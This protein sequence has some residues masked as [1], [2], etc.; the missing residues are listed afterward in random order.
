ME[1]LE[2]LDDL[3]TTRIDTTWP[4]ISGA[5]GLS[6]AVEAL[7]E[8]AEKA[9]DEGVETIILSDRKINH[10]RVGIPS[11]LAV[12]AVHRHLG[13]AKKRMR[14][15]IIIDTAEA[16]D[17]HQMACL[18][19]FGATAICPWLAHE[20]VRELVEKNAKKKFDEVSLDKALINYHKAL[21]KGRS[22]DSFEDGN[23]G[24]EQLSG[25]TDFRGGR[26]LG[27]CHRSLFSPV[28]LRRLP[29]S[30]FTKLE[31]RALARHTAAFSE[32]VPN[33]KGELVLGGSWPLPFPSRWRDPRDQR[34]SHKK[35]PHLRQERRCG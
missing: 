7:C 31:P 10:D 29:V 6:D 24:S 4:L 1:A 9:V 17:T 32:A 8:K 5:E 21:E 12:G 2:A 28:R 15:S 14:T 16:R 27:R 25:R 34:W 26:N 20:T 35:F 22:Q 33:D 3:Q 18:I 30:V 11:L 23:L 13:D 19:G